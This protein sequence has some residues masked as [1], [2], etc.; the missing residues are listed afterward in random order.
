M[1]DEPYVVNRVTFKYT[2]LI[3]VD[4]QYHKSASVW[5]AKKKADDFGLQLVCFNQQTNTDLPLCKIIDFGK[6]RYENEK[7]NKKV[8]LEQR[9]GV[10]EVRFSAQISDNDIAHKV[11]HAKEFLEEGNSLVLFMKVHGRDLS[12]MDLAEAK[13]T[14]IINDIASV[15]KVISRK[16]EGGQIV[17]KMVKN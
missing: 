2:R 7:H 16:T 17:A 14:A 1:N 5:D 13:M 11:K 6:W 4:G 12:H 15:G 10:K 9:R 8:Q 3:D